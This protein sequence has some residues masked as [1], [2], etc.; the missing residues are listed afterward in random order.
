VCTRYISRSCPDDALTECISCFQCYAVCPNNAITFNKREIEEIGYKPLID[1]ED[2]KSFLAYRRSNRIFSDKPV[3]RKTI[4]ELVHSAQL[5]PSGGNAHDCKFTMI[6]DTE[7][8]TR[9][10][11]LIKKRYVFQAKLLKAPVVRFLLKLFSDPVTRA[12]LNDPEYFGRI[13]PLLEG[14]GKGKDNLFYNAPVIIAVHSDRLIPTPGPDCILAAYN[15]VL[16]AHAMGLGT[17]FVTLAQNAI[18]NS[19]RCRKLLN[20]GKKEK[21]HAVLLLGYNKLKYLRPVPG[22]RNDRCSFITPEN[23]LKVG[24]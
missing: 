24:A 12:F 11:N 23:L 7:V 8:K 20:L 3:K 13:T 17:C 6:T 21:I 15:I 5:I 19:S 16:M 9:L 4:L 18:N 10:F 1:K 14:L 2:L 22:F